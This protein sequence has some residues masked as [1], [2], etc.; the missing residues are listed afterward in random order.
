MFAFNKRLG[1]LLL[2]LTMG[3]STVW[4][5]E[6]TIIDEVIAVVGDNPVLRSDVEFQ[7]Q[8]AMMQGNNFQGDLK[9]H[10]FEQLLLQNLLL[11][12][13]KLD[14]IEVSENMVISQVDRQINEF[15]NRAGSR[16]KLEEWLNKPLHQIKMEQRTIVRNQM[17]KIGRAHV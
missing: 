16:E 2:V 12:Q 9:C 13:A 5:Q 10:I 11:E 8:Q 3:F 15:I 7:F 14:S 17:L 1:S 4:A 6:G